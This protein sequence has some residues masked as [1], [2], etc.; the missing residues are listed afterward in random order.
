MIYDH[1]YGHL[2]SESYDLLHICG[3]IPKRVPGDLD[4]YLGYSILG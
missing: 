3:G 4:V 1:T 2:Q